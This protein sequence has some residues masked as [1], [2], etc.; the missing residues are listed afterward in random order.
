MSVVARPYITCRQL[1]DFIYDY[2]EG[3]LPTEQRAE[4]DRH[5]AVCPSCINYL[6]TYK[7]TPRLGKLALRPGADDGSTTEADEELPEA[8]VHSIMSALSR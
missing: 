2:L 8:L 1:L 6:E 3:S 4:F 7:Q 5:L